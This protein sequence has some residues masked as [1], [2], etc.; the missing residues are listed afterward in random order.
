MITSSVEVECLTEWITS[1]LNIE[2][3][4]L[5]M[6]EVG[7]IT[8]FSTEIGLTGTGYYIRLTVDMPEE[9]EL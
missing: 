3:K 4:M 8:D 5:D 7:K 2:G 1:L 6:E 9:D